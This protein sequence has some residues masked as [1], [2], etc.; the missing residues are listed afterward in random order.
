M[1]AVVEQQ[2]PSRLTPPLSPLSPPSS[3]PATIRSPSPIEFDAFPQVNEEPPIRALTASQYYLIHETYYSTPL[4]NDL[5]PWLH[6]IDGT[7]PIQNSFFGLKLQEECPVPIHRGVIVVQAEEMARSQLV[8]SVLPTDILDYGNPDDPEDDCSARGFLKIMDSEGI[9]LRN[10]KIQVAKYATISDIIVYGENGLNENV[11]NIAKQMAWAQKKFKEENSNILEY[12]V[13]VIIEPFS[14]FEEEY[15]ELVAIDSQGNVRNKIDFSNREREEMQTLT[16]AS[17]ISTN[18]WL[19]NTQD[20]PFSNG[21][22][23]LDPADSAISLIDDNPHQFCVCIE[24]HDIAETP[25]KDTLCFITEQLAQIP[26]PRISID[27]IVHLDCISTGLGFNTPDAFDFA[28]TR[29]LDLCEFVS[30][31]A[32]NFD[33]K[34]LIYCTDG[35]TETSLFAITYLMFRENLNLPQAYLKLQKTRSFFVY[36]HDMDT[37]LKIEKCI[38]ERKGINCDETKRQEEY[39]WFYSTPC[40]EGSFPSRILPFLYLGNLNHACNANMLKALGINHVLSVGEDSRLD[41]KDFQVLYLNNLFD[42]GIDSLWNHLDSCV[43]F[44]ERARLLNGKVLIH[45]RV[46]VSRSATITIAYI[47]RHLGYSLVSSYLFV[48]ARRLNV[49]I[50]PNLRFMYELLQYEQK[51]NGKM[52]ISWPLLAKDIHT[53]NMCYVG[54]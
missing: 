42:D 14:I 43:N 54:S 25:D 37:L 28:V 20:V 30:D 39:P 51:L 12:E 24:S 49:I 3:S 52:G 9:N 7:N 40:F 10:F 11:L 16:A 22:D 41:N 48:R 6:G 32:N 36:P 19:G 5:F 18:V 4:P 47:M 50:Q 33:H 29:L 27:D 15:P 17:E 1:A 23:P 8:G 21:L 38:F 13:F 35:Y 34:I 53:L 26:Q 46:G 45:C 2:Q 44:I 31:Q